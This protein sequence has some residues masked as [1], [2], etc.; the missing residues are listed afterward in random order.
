MKKKIQE[1][2]LS[3]KPKEAIEYDIKYRSNLIRLKKNA[4]NG[5]LNFKTKLVK[6]ISLE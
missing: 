2:I 1:L 4:K 3:L 6:R 5:K